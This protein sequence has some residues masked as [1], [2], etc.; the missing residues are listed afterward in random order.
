M[1][2]PKPKLLQHGT[3]HGFTFLLKDR[4]QVLSFSF[5]V[6]VSWITYIFVYTH[7]PITLFL[8]YPHDDTLYL[9]R[10]RDLANW[11]WMG[12]FD[13]FTL[14]KGPGYP[15]FLAFVNWTGLPVSLA[16]ALLNCIAVTCFVA[17]CRRLLGS[18]LLSA[19][20][21]TLLLWHPYWFTYDTLRIIREMIYPA[22]VLLVMSLVI[23]TTFIGKTTALRIISAALAGV[24]LGWFWLTREEGVWIIPGV[25]I[26]LLAALLRAP[27]KWREWAISLGV[28]LSIT[29][30]VQIGFAALNWNYYGKFVGV[31]FKETNY[32]RALRA[33]HSVTPGRPYVSV[34]PATLQRLYAVSPTFKS[35]EPYF[36]GFGRSWETI[37]CNLIPITCGGISP[38]W[39]VWALRD[40]AAH[41]RRYKSP[42]DASR[43][44]RRVADE[45]NVACEDG[46][47]SCDSQ[48][49]AEMPHVT[50]NE[51]KTLPQH[52]LTAFHMLLFLSPSEHID[53][54]VGDE[55]KL[56]SALEFLN[57]PRHT[58][59]MS[60]SSSVVPKANLSDK[61]AAR[62]RKFVLKNY[63]VLM[64]PTLVLGIL[65][66]LLSTAFYFRTA[67]RNCAY[68]VA[69]ACWTLVL[70]RISLLVLMSATSVPIQA[71]IPLY[72]S[73]A[74][75]MMVSAAVLSLGA[76]VQLS[77]ANFR[78]PLS[79]ATLIPS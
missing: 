3:D 6:I 15:L 30:A 31:D 10:A 47:L 73:A 14:M 12:S 18:S 51:I 35:L 39:F 7:T 37:S 25:A 70:S 28:M 58:R 52:Y 50:W 71:D 29:S 54:S 68:I 40:A 24:C 34:T 55:E 21:F 56:T 46:K 4:G 53:A 76:F 38:A 9:A 1:I 74:F 49:V 62:M 72:Y 11:R 44:F 5:F 42:K 22:Q 66:F 78:K 2:G 32:Q 13:Q 20:L 27:G 77:R 23:Y 60:T 59:P 57:Y 16:A 33:I 63:G 17:V 45:I 64:L 67:L 61:V 8:H 79:P 48:W 43:F 75:F 36:E 69:F 26:L 19:V 65:G 41:K